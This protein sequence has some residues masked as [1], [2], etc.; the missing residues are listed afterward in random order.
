MEEQGIIPEFV[1]GLGNQLFIA[2]AAFVVSKIK[3]I[4]L[5]LFFNPLSNNPHN[6]KHHNY[7]ESVFRYFGT[8]V[9]LDVTNK[10][11]LEKL[12]YRKYVQRQAFE[13]W[14]PENVNQGSYLSGYFQYYPP[15]KLFENELRTIIIK[16]IQEYR[17]K[18]KVDSNS[19]FLHVRRGDYT[20]KADYHYLQPIEYYQKSVENL[21]ALQTEI[22]KIYVI[23]D[24]IDWVKQQDFFKKEIF[25]LYENSDELETLA[26]MSLCYGGAICA[27]STFS[28]WGAF[29]GAYSQRNPVFIPTNWI[30]EKIWNL[31]PEEWIII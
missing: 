21:L 11:V 14:N 7:N 20:T 22:P 8:Y 23:S 30:R 5:Y 9:H 15:I 10:I 24:D 4:P 13:P 6:K 29:L 3:N 25:E 26:L 2:A 27:N 17:N 12:K 19:A 28:W 16:G 31:F 1:G 18:I